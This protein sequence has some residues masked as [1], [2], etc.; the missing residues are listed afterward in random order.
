M[1]I[2]ATIFNFQRLY[3]GKGETNEGHLS[4]RI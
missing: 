3:V 2:P 1:D 4:W